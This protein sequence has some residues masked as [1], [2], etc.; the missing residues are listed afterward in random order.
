MEIVS[1]IKEDP[2]LIKYAEKAGRNQDI[3]TEINAMVEKLRLGNEQC[4]RGRKTLFRDVKE[5]RGYEGGRIYYRKYNG[6]IEILGKSSKVPREQQA[7]IDI[8]KKLY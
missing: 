8:L 3:Q 6:K 5:L 7:V 1:R 4:G 2:G